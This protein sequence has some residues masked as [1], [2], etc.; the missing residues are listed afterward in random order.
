MPQEESPTSE[1]YFH[2]LNMLI[3]DSCRGK[4]GGSPLKYFGLLGSLVE[5]IKSKPPLEVIF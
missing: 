2:F 1:Q 5:K 4:E 3:K